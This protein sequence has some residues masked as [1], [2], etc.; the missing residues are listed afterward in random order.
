MYSELLAFNE[1]EKKSIDNTMLFLFE[2]FSED[3]ATGNLEPLPV[4]PIKESYNGKG[5]DFLTTAYTFF[6]GG[7]LKAL[8]VIENSNTQETQSAHNTQEISE[9]LEKR[10]DI[11]RLVTE[12]TRLPLEKQFSIIKPITKVLAE[13]G[14]DRTD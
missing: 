9:I 8:E 10:T 12:L 2:Q 7:V 3:L 11:M 13:Y 6:T 14:E 4:A 5:G 1:E